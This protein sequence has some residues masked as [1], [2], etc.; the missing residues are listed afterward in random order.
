MPSPTPDRSDAARGALPSARR[1][2]RRIAIGVFW[3]FTVAVATASAIQVTQQV[4][5]D[6]CPGGLS[7]AGGPTPVSFTNCREGLL[8]LH[9]AVERARLAAAGTDGEDAALARF[10]AGLTPEWGHRDDVAGACRGAAEDEGALDAI[11]RL[12]YA[13]EHAVRREAGELAPLR[14]RVEAIVDRELSRPG[15]PTPAPEHSAHPNP[16]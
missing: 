7:C 5:F 3:A 10:R 13:E 4:L 9:G 8:A 15:T 11:E 16:P 1:R 14:R 6:P 12:R 2:G